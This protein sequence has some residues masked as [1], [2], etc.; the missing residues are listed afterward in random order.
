MLT[1]GRN[2][3]T[4]SVR[5]KFQALVTSIGRISM[6]VDLCMFVFGQVQRSAARFVAG[7]Y[8]R[9]SCVSAMCANLKCQCYVC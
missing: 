3:L 1:A 5:V 8:Q 7:D 2:E 4:I 6:H 9:T